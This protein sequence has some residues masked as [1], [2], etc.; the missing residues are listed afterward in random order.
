MTAAF[1]EFGIASLDYCGGALRHGVL[2]DLVRRSDGADLRT[3]TVAQMIS[4]HG[5]DARQAGRV[6]D[7][8][9]A[10]FDVENYE[11]YVRVQAEAGMSQPL[12]SMLRRRL[13][14]EFTRTGITLV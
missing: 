10:S 13:Y 4:R 14:A 12:A 6:R 3:T 1:D 2:H 8:A 7:T 9:Q 5:I 11:Q